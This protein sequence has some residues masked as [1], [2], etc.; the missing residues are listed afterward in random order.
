[1]YSTIDREQEGFRPGSSSPW[2]F[3]LRII[4]EQSAEYRCDLHLDFVDFGNAFDCVDKEGLWMAR[5]RRG[6]SN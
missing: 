3:M 6:M 1:M 4:I 2:I 5:R